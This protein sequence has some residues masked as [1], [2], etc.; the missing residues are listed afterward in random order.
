M[1]QIE[2]RSFWEGQ[3]VT[4]IYPRDHWLCRTLGPPSHF[5][6]LRGWDVLSHS[7]KSRCERRSQPLPACPMPPHQLGTKGQLFVASP[8]FHGMWAGNQMWYYTL[9]FPELHMNTK[10][11]TFPFSCA[12]V[13]FWKTRL[14][15]DVLSNSLPV[16]QLYLNMSNLHCCM[17]R[18]KISRWKTNAEEKCI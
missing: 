17:G 10:E 5:W 12:F 6:K 13:C 11:L 15:N 18:K 4:G 8:A 1:W 14:F 9:G 3:E 16:V 2:L 7:L